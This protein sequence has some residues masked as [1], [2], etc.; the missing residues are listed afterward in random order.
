MNVSPEGLPLKYTEKYN[1]NVIA[2]AKMF[3]C[4]NL[5]QNEN[6]HMTKINGH[7]VSNAATYIMTGSPH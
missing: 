4:V 5:T 7:F 1:F 3:S 2:P 6:P